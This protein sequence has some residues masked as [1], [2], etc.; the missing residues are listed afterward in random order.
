MSSQSRPEAAI[1]CAYAP[2]R[3]PE[4]QQRGN[5]PEAHRPGSSAGAQFDVADVEDAESKNRRVRP[6]RTAAGPGGWRG[7]A[8][9]FGAGRSAAANSILSRPRK[10]R[11]RPSENCRAA[12]EKASASPADEKQPAPGRGECSWLSGA[13]WR[14]DDLRT[15]TPPPR[16]QLGG[17]HR[18]VEKAPGRNSPR[19]VSTGTGPC[20]IPRARRKRRRRTKF[21]GTSAGSTPALSE[22]ANEFLARENCAPRRIP[23]GPSFDGLVVGPR[24]PAAVA[25]R[26][27]ESAFDGEA[28]FQARGSRC[29]SRRPEASVR[30]GERCIELAYAWT[31]LSY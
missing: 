8:I 4:T 7:G 12:S 27:A 21:A 11:S 6:A 19:P 5:R 20:T 18:A 26:R 28:W 16:L 10:P 15:G 31:R 1:P 3:P 14:Q 23:P 24:T 29:S 22:G 25:A 9:S 30:K 17:L 13:C 2:R